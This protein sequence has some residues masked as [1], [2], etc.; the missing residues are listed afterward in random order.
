METNNR[1]DY[2]YLKMEVR[3]LAPP[4][5]IKMGRK[6][7]EYMGSPLIKI[8]GPLFGFG[9]A[10]HKVIQL[11]EVFVEMEDS[12]KLATSIYLP[13]KLY[14]NK[15]KCP[16]ILVRLPYWKD[17]MYS[18]FG[19]AF[20]A[21]GYAVVLQDA[22]GCAHSEGFNF[23]LMTERMDGLKTLEWISR[24]FWYNGK[25]GMSGGSYFGMTQWCV[26]WDNPY[27]TCIAPAICCISN[28][29]KK[30]QG[31]NIHSLT[32]SIYRIMINISANREEPL[33]NFLTNE[34]LELY[35]NPKFALYNEPINK[36]GEYLKFSDFTGKSIDECVKILA[37]FYKIQ[38]FDLG[39][40]NFN[41][42]FKFLKDFLY[43]EKD[44]D[45]MPGLLDI[46]FKK[47]SQPAFVQAGWYD[48]FLEHQIKDFMEIKKEST[49][50]ARKYSKLV[51]GPWGHAHKGHPEG[52]IIDFLKEFLK[53]DWYD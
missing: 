32:T 29:W 23:F 20:A 7:I 46:D 11:D 43:L 37:D 12:T 22:R 21:Y 45:N 24:Q 39:E 19:Y 27:L 10:K 26:S 1:I 42:Y 33:V 14:R 38:K 18:I 30:H 13:Q 49:G 25:I 3:P 47:L 31:L 36:T 9:R 40:R 44:I 41:T 50:E 8:L 15:E 28:L 51:I 35:T 16:T 53:I 52:N 34:I 6:L 17:G 4:P 5:L 2:S 48:M